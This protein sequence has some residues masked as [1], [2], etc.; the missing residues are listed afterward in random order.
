[1]LKVIRAQHSRRPSFAPAPPFVKGKGKE[2]V[3][4]RLWIHRSLGEQVTDEEFETEERV[5]VVVE[6]GEEAVD[7]AVEEATE[8][9]VNEAVDE[10]I[11]E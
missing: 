11:D 1:L 8:K 9:A 3:I 2:Q 6:D 7:G 5:K 10:A 4:H